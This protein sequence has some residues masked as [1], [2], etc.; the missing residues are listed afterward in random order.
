[1]AM[2]MKLLA[3][4]I[5]AKSFFGFDSN[6]STIASFLA[7]AFSLFVSKSEED[8]EKKATSA[9][10]ISAEQPNKTTSKTILVICVKSKVL[11]NNSKPGGSVSN[12]MNL[13]K[14]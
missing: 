13:V 3:T 7:I 10:E 6:F 14:H 8:K 1:M 12:L 9:P 11:I 5:V 4:R 2:F